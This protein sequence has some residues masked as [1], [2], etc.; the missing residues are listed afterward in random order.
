MMNFQGSFMRKTVCTLAALP[1]FHK[2]KPSIKVLKIDKL[3]AIVTLFDNSK[4]EHF[5]SLLV[6]SDYFNFYKKY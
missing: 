2:S 1:Y 4:T 6:I 3:K 5:I